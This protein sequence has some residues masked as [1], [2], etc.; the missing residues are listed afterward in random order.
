MNSK[1]R[2]VACS[3]LLLQ[4]VQSWHSIGKTRLA[5][6]LA[7]LPIKIITCVSGKNWSKGRYNINTYGTYNRIDFIHSFVFYYVCNERQALRLPRLCAFRIV[8]WPA[9]FRSAYPVTWQRLVKWPERYLAVTTTLY[10]LADTV[11][12]LI[13]RWINEIVIA[14]HFSLKWKKAQSHKLFAVSI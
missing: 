2:R 5:G 7:N 14:A 4:W 1:L 12:H 11:C 9:D 6:R 8:K 13:H 3:I 10:S